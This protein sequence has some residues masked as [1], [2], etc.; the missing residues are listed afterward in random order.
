[1]HPRRGLQAPPP[2]R[3]I[4]S[5]SPSSSPAYHHRK[6]LRYS[7][8]SY[9]RRSYYSDPDSVD[10]Y[11]TSPTASYD[12]DEIIVDQRRPYPTNSTSISASISTSNRLHHHQNAPLAEPKY[13]AKPS[14]PPLFAHLFPSTRRLTIKHDD[15]PD[16]NMNLSIDTNMSHSSE[17]PRWVTLFHMK[18]NN[19][20]GRDMALRRYGRDCGREVVNFRRKYSKSASSRPKLERSRSKLMNSLMGKPTEPKDRSIVRQDSGYESADNNDDD[21]EDLSDIDNHTHPSTTPDHRSSSAAPTS[22]STSTLN[23]GIPTNTTLLEFS[24]YAHVDLKRRGSKGSKRYEFEYWGKTYAWRRKIT[25]YGQEES[26]SY[27][28]VNV[29]TNNIIAHIRPD[30]LSP[31][32]VAEEQSKGGFVPPSTMWLCDDTDDTVVSS[33]D[34]AD[35]VVATGVYALIDDSIKRKFSRRKKIVQLVLPTMRGNTVKMNMEYVGPK[36][37]IDQVFNRPSSSPRKNTAPSRPANPV[38]TQTSNPT[39]GALAAERAISRP[40]ALRAASTRV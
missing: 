7:D 8:D 9:S 4:A 22:T 2:P 20:R 21:D 24:N 10:T 13:F 36:R 35:V 31:S 39:T 25:V 26:C 6:D 19:L 14:S 27:Y 40:I 1:M 3:I 37:L 30:N 12:D 16:G 34:V 33:S 15:S 38:R 5:P 28:L 18:M 23:P 32:E 17:P 11:S 29:A